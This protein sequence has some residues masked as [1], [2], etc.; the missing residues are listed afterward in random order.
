MKRIESQRLC[1]SDAWV[2]AYIIVYLLASLPHHSHSYSRSCV[3]ESTVHFKLSK[4][5]NCSRC[6]HLTDERFSYGFVYISI[7]GLAFNRFVMRR[8]KKDGSK[9]N[10]STQAQALNK[11]IVD[12]VSCSLHHQQWDCGNSLH[13]KVH[14]NMPVK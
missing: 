13:T 10:F 14:I 9:R 12:N 2:Y 7:F 11:K 6:N 8:K 5:M 1:G 4:Q 3:C